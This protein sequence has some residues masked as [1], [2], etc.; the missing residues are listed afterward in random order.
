LSGLGEYNQLWSYFTN[1]PDE[2]ISTI[3]AFNSSDRAKQEIPWRDDAFLTSEEQCLQVLAELAVACNARLVIRHHPRLG[4]EQRS[5]FTS[6][7]YPALASHCERLEKQ[8]PGHIKI[9][10]PEAQINSYELALISNHVI[11]FR[12]T[13]PLE[14]SL[15]GIKPIV[16]AKDQG[17]MNYW[18][19][20]HAEDAPHDRRMLLDQL[21]SGPECYSPQELGRL[22]CEFF[23]LNQGGAIPLEDIA[24]SDRLQ[25]SL[26]SG[27]SRDSMDD[28]LTGESEPMDSTELIDSVHIYLYKVRDLVSVA[29]L[30]AP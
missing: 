8:Y 6:T 4:P 14:C 11:S 13:M 16:L 10:Q 27:N 28:I 3:H 12:G 25:Q 30:G 18:I 29:F 19:T 9:I 5:A 17:V 24:S 15:L 21:T 2:L 1:S 20:L 7:A 22:L 26:L 23:L